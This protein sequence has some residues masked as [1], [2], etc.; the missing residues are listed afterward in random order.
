M[1]RSQE[2]RKFLLSVS[3]GDSELFALCGSTSASVLT[4]AE[5]LRFPHLPAFF[6]S[7]VLLEIQTCMIQFVT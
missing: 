7:R 6:P 5:N 4:T 1:S 2:N 3:K